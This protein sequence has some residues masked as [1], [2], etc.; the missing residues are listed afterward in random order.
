MHCALNENIMS[1]CE[2][3][4]G[5]EICVHLMALSHQQTPI[6]MPTPK[7]EKVTMYVNESQSLNQILVQTFLNTVINVCL[8][9]ISFN[10]GRLNFIKLSPT[11]PYMGHPLRKLNDIPEHCVFY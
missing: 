10:L 3:Q 6:P 9:G 5:R 8:V 2:Y 4:L 11:D 1:K 7:C